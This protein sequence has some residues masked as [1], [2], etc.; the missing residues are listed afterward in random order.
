M[1]AG[2][3]GQRSSRYQCTDERGKCRGSKEAQS[4]WSLGWQGPDLGVKTP[5]L[6]VELNW[7]PGGRG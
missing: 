3:S 5:G 2:V 6:Q 7:R 1:M 4:G